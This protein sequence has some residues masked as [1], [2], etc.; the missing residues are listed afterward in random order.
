M[1]L[2]KGEA[3]AIIGPSGSGKSS[4]FRAIAGIWPPAAGAVGRP[5]ASAMFLPQRPYVPLG[6][7]RQAIAYPADPRIHTE[8]AIRE[9]LEDVG[10]GEKASELDDATNWTQ[11]LS[12]GEQQRL[13]IGRALLGHPDWLFLDE[14]TASLDPEAAA[15][16]YSV[17]ARRLPDT[18]LVSITHREDIALL[19]ERRIVFERLQGRRGRVSEKA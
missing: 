2:R 9:A 16:I 12:G 7:L 6:T 13:A 3:T 18:T 8:R 11:R 14:A 4:L 10:L 19:H 5:A 17:L 15:A 1:R